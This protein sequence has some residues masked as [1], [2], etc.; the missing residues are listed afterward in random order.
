MSGESYVTWGEP[1][2]F[3]HLGNSIQP[4]RLLSN[5]LYGT[6][7]SMTNETISEESMRG[8]PLRK[9]SHDDYYVSQLSSAKKNSNDLK[10]FLSKNPTFL[11][12]FRKQAFGSLAFHSID[13]MG[14]EEGEWYS[15]DREG[16]IRTHSFVSAGVYKAQRTSRSASFRSKTRS[17]RGTSS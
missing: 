13:Y 2:Q 15:V 10:S 9:L 1:N 8:Q 12:T 4:Y 7:Q 17:K 6:N 5:D 14:E 16:K 11:G 3:D